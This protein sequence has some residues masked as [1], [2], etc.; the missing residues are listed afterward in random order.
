MIED[1][2]G[3]IRVLYYMILYDK[4]I[5]YYDVCL[6]D[7]SACQG[8]LF[9]TG[10]LYIMRRITRFN[11]QSVPRERVDFVS[12]LLK[13]FSMWQILDVSKGAAAFYMWVS[14]VK[15]HFCRKLTL[16]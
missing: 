8:L 11:I 14:M 6:Q 1:N 4:F 10:H 15:L 9:R 13:D 16:N 7:F 5:L 2:A 12:R 3:I